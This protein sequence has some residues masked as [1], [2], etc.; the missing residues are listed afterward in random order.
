MVVT[1]IAAA[2]GAAWMVELAPGAESSVHDLD[3]RLS[4]QSAESLR[5]ERKADRAKWLSRLTRGE[6]GESATYGRPI[7]QLLGERLPVTVTLVGQGLALAWS[8]ALP[9]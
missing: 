1:L 4:D 8:A 6:L 9:G 3:A 7:A 5:A 2:L